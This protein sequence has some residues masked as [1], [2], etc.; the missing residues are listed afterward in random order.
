MKAWPVAVILAL[1]FAALSNARALDVN[2]APAL[3]L[4]EGA[5]T[6]GEFIAEPNMQ[7]VRME[8]VLGYLSGRNREAASPRERYVGRSFQ[9]PATVIGWLKNY[10]QSH[11]LD[12][13]NKAADDLRADFQRHEGH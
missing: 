6:C 9:Q 7:T 5:T 11:G 10:C 12:I 2:N 8:W 3:V 13:L 1:I 4:S